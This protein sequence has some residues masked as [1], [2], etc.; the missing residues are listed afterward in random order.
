MARVTGDMVGLS[1]T[2]LSH[3]VR[4]LPRLIR[5]VQSQPSSLPFRFTNHRLKR[6]KS[7]HKP[8]LPTPSF[9]PDFSLLLQ[10]QNPIA[11]PDLYV[12]HKTLPPRVFVPK[13]PQCRAGEYDRPRQMSAQERQWWSSPYRVSD[14]TVLFFFKIKI[15]TQFACSQHLLATVLSQGASCHQ[16][17]FLEPFSIPLYSLPWDSF[18]P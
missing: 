1:R 6:P 9:H 4:L 5:I 16:V 8:T 18:S 10:P 13:N 14:S 12:R 11:T 2:C 3:M 7:L 17:R 15:S